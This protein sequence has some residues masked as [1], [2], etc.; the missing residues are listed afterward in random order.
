MKLNKIENIS[1]LWALCSFCRLKGV[2]LYFSQ[3]IR[4]H[5]A[6][7]SLQ[8]EPQIGKNY[9]RKRDKKKQGD[10]RIF[11]MIKS[12]EKAEK[13]DKFECPT[14]FCINNILSSTK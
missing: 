9:G 2:I 7:D 5:Q 11:K 1:T 13:S 3:Q 8:S 12:G 4:C 10:E 6:W 14:F